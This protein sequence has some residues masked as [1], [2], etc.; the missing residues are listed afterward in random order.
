ME[1]FFSIV[2]P[3][4]NSE[5]YL[6]ECLKSVLE[7]RFES[8]EIIIIDDGSVD[9]TYEIAKKY[10]KKDAR[11]R[12]YK[13][14]NGG[15]A[16]A[17]N[18]GII[19]AEGKYIVFLDSDDILNEGVLEQIYSQLSDSDCD[20]AICNGYVE[21]NGGGGEALSILCLVRKF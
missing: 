10:E 6:N 18:M 1:C 13:K 19:N 9:N 11:V 17:R 4:Y 16:S 2:I 3:A 14:I 12:A 8:F 20:M 5:K 15:V 21:I 7:Q